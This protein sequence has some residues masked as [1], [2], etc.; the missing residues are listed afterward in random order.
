MALCDETAQQCEQHANANSAQGN[1]KEAEG[2]EGKVL[3]NQLVGP[4]LDESEEHSVED[5]ATIWGILMLLKGHPSTH[6]ADAIIQQ[7]F[8]KNADE[9]PLVDLHLLEYHDHGHRVNIGNQR[10]EKQL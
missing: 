8:A 10:A 5:L 3:A 7:G 9:Q 2:A 4:N 6:H 1:H